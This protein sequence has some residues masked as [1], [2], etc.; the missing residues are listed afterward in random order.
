MLIQSQGSNG[1]AAI[2]AAGS[3]EKTKWVFTIFTTKIGHVVMIFTVIS[4][5]NSWGLLSTINQEFIARKRVCAV[6]FTS[7]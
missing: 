3:C 2:V 1:R 6:L 4:S 5:P 7:T